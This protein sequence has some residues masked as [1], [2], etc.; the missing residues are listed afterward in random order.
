MPM[1]SEDQKVRLAD[2]MV[3][4]M[5]M[6]SA[7]YKAQD[8]LGEPTSESSHLPLSVYKLGDGTLLLS[9]GH[10]RIADV[11]IKMNNANEVL[12]TELEAEVHE[13]DYEDLDD[14]PDESF[15]EWGDF[16]HW[17][18]DTGDWHL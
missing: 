17:L 4:E 13:L 14:V 15:S 1:F 5:N 9:D 6:D 18:I 11:I 10:H 7:Y 16:G 2:L 8:N 3:D 12:N